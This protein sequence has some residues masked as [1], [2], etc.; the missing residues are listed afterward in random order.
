MDG[1]NIEIC[2][3]TSN[4]VFLIES[5]FT[6]DNHYYQAALEDARQAFNDIVLDFGYHQKLRKKPTL[7]PNSHSSTTPALITFSST[8]FQCFTLFVI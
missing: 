5:Y 8:N 3:T 7:S 6:K 4:A 2:E 1:Q